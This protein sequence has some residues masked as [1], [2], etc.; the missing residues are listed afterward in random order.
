MTSFGFHRIP[1]RTAAFRPFLQKW[2]FGGDF[3]LAFAL[4][5][6]SWGDD[7]RFRRA[8]GGT[9][10]NSKHGNAPPKREKGFPIFQIS[11]YRI[12]HQFTPSHMVAVRNQVDALQAIIIDIVGEQMDGHGVAACAAPNTKDSMTAVV[13]SPQR[14][15]KVKPMVRKSLPCGG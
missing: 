15:E 5:T 14:R 2:D 3:E 8:M 6:R 10:T 4:Q 13:D 9:L 12:S 7:I 1:P 11:W